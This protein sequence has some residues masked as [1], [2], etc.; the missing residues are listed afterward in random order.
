MK[1]HTVTITEVLEKKATVPALNREA[2]KE[3][4]QNR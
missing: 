2:E 4:A 3:E 1:E